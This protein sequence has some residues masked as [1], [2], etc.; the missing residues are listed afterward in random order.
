MKL[1]DCF[2]L[3]LAA[4]LLIS[5]CATGVQWTEDGRRIILEDDFRDD[6]IENERPANWQWWKSSAVTLE[7]VDDAPAG[8]GPTVMRLGTGGSTIHIGM[9]VEN[10]TMWNLSDYRVKVL[11]TDR[12]VSLSM[13]DADFHIGIR[14]MPPESKL[15]NVEFGYE[16]EIDGDDTDATNLVPEDGP[17]HFHMM[18]RGEINRALDF[19][20]AEEFPRPVRDQWYWTIFEASGPV[21]R[22]KTW[23]YGDEEPDWMMVTVDP[24]KEFQSGGIRMGVWSGGV[25]VAYV[26]VEEA[27]PVSSDLMTGQG[28]SDQYEPGPWQSELLEIDNQGKLIYHPDTQGHYL[29]DFSY[30]GYRYGADI[31]TVPVK[32]EV[33][34]GEG[35]DTARIQ[36]AIDS[37]ESFPLENG[38][39]GAVLLAPGTYEIEGTIRVNQSGVVLRGSGSGDNPAEDTILLG[40]GNKVPGRS[41]IRA[42][43]GVKHL[44]ETRDDALQ[45]VVSDNYVPQGSLFFELADT[46]GFAVGDRIIINHPCTEEWLEAVRGGDT[47]ADPSWT[48]GQLPIIFYRKITS[49]EG[50]TIGLD[51]PLYYQLDKSLAETTVTK[52]DGSFMLENIGV[53]SL[54][55]DIQT[56]G[57]AKDQHA[58]N[59]IEVTGLENGWVRN[60][61]LLHFQLSGVITTSSVGISILGN[62]ATEPVQEI[63]P[64]WMYNFNA[65]TGSQLILFSGNHAANGRHHYVINGT[66]TA[67][68]IVFHRNTSSDANATSEGHRQWSTGILYDNHIE[69]D[70]P[71]TGMSPILLALYNRGDLGTGHGWSAANSVL[72]NCDVNKGMIVAQQPPTSQ[73]FAIGCFGGRVTGSGRYEFPKGYIEG[74]NRRELE[75]ASLYEAQLNDRK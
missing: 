18:T 50:N 72:W 30:A 51:A 11:W 15:H 32:I 45:T 16:I 31:P 47:G 4:L 14:C 55:V 24:E 48:P 62:K 17:S 42:G 53:E 65:Y 54:R 40:V 2:F 36:D 43:Y 39:R 44:W 59:A 69:L 71:K 9:D 10:E 61:E 67:S 57:S 21:L 27:E 35:D 5:T 1:R 25:D 3:A 63:V 22:A 49:I 73:N 37:M 34:P 6:N 7:E 75:P 66:S 41:I 26:S 68:G 29:P 23:K 28:Q 19:T 52:Y 13:N 38:F 46:S 20:T 60:T 74:A 64:P 70:G 8:Y 12:H 33:S 58:K 56:K